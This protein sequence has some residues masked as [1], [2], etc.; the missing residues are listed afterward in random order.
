MI[1]YTSHSGDDWVLESDIIVVMI[2]VMWSAIKYLRVL[3]KKT[4]IKAH[5][6]QRLLRLSVGSKR[7]FQV[8]GQDV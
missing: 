8:P 4:H 5:F 2:L 3:A 6:V 1:M 7:S